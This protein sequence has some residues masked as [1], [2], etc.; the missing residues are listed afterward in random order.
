MRTGFQVASDL[1]RKATVLLV[2]AM[3]GIQRVASVWIIARATDMA[4]LGQIASDISIASIF[5]FATA[6]GWGGLMLVRLPRLSAGRQA[7]FSTTIAWN[8]LIATAAGGLLIALLH[9]MGLVHSF[10][11]TL[12]LLASLTLYQL[13]RHFSLALKEY[14][15]LLYVETFALAASLGAL[16]SFISYDVWWAYLSLSLPYLAMGMAW[17]WRWIAV[18]RQARLRLYG[19]YRGIWSSGQGF[20]L[21]TGL[22]AGLMASV[23]PVAQFTAG[24]THAGVTAII[25][26]L[27]NVLVLFPRALGL[28]H[29]VTMTTAY[30][31]HD[32]QAVRRVLR[33]FRLHV[34]F[35]TAGVSLLAGFAWFSAAGLAY[36][37]VD[38]IS[39]SNTIFVF[40]MLT[41]AASQLALPDSNLLMC[42]ER[43]RLQLAYNATHALIYATGVAMAIWLFDAGAKQFFV[44]LAVLLAATLFRSLLVSTAAQSALRSLGRC[45]S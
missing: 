44:V 16:A 36:P 32:A 22:T 11:G 34:A 39:H 35:A 7:Q 19:Q 29:L 45:T 37:G 12:L 15:T 10:W 38:A 24:E 14:P 27:V 6:I 30:G 8:S 9:E 4:T 23:V 40:L 41:F 13:A 2:T 26:S 42:A 28:H 17:A 18:A 33:R 5:G 43:V 20:A 1:L 25:L 21:N 31:R 3:P